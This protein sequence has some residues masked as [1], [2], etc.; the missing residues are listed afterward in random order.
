[1]SNFLKNRSCNDDFYIPQPKISRS[2]V[3]PIKLEEKYYENVE[4]TIHNNLNVV[5]G[6]TT[7][8]EFIF[9]SFE[10]DPRLDAIDA[11]L[12]AEYK[13][14]TIFMEM[15]LSEPEDEERPSF[16]N[17]YIRVEDY[18]LSYYHN[19]TI[20]YLNEIKTS[21]SDYKIVKPE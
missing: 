17:K 4:T 21:M 20:A 5:F 7:K 11:K 16:D 6:T 18:D 15:N 14:E 10:S 9:K 3:K 1:M 13:T 19:A 8:G 2:T 12:Q